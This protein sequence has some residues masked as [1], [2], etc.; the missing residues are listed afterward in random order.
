MTQ[1]FDFY[2][3]TI[4]VTGADGPLEELRRDFSYFVAPPS[5]EPAVRLTL[6][7]DPPPYGDLP[8]MPVS[9]ITLRNACFEDQAVTYIDYF[10]HGLLG[11]RS[12]PWNAVNHDGRTVFLG[13]HTEHLAPRTE[14]YPWPDGSGPLTPPP[15]RAT[16]WDLILLS[17]AGADPGE[18]SVPSL[19]RCLREAGQLVRPGGRVIVPSHPG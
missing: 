13:G 19:S 16:A 1:V 15:L 11:S 8:E 5:P 18:S 6:L 2:G 12:C 7:L 4:E 9:F 10:G 3:L 14:S 17:G